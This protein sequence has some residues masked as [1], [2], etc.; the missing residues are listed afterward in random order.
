MVSLPPF[1]VLLAISV[2][3]IIVAW[4]LRSSRRPSGLP[5]GPP[6]LPI[7][8]NALEIS[9]DNT[10]KGLAKWGKLYG[11][12][13]AVKAFSQTCIVINSPDAANEI[14]SKSSATTSHRIVR[15][16]ALLSGWE[17]A[18]PHLQP[19]AEFR[20]HRQYMKIAVG[21]AAMME[22][23]PEHE[24]RAL[25]LVQKL[26]RNPKEI[27]N[28]VAFWIAVSFEH[29]AYGTDEEEDFSG[30][31]EMGRHALKIFQETSSPMILWAVDIL[32]SL[33]Y[34]PSWLPGMGF[35]RQA[36]TWRMYMRELLDKAFE[37]SVRRMEAGG[38]SSCLISRVAE[39]QPLDTL[40]ENSKEI[41]KNAALNIYVGGFDTM[42]SMVLSFF[43][44]MTLYPDVQKGAQLKVDAVTH[45]LRL[46]TFAD[47]DS[48]PCIDRMVKEVLRWAVPTTLVFPHSQ[49]P[50]Q[51]AIV[52]GVFIP[53]GSLLIVN[54]GGIFEDPEIY[55]D[56]RRFWPDRFLDDNVLDP[57]SVAFGY[58]R[59]KCIGM[60][61]V[62]KRLWITIATALATLDVCAPTN[63]GARAP[64]AAWT[65]GAMRLPLSFDAVFNVRHP[66]LIEG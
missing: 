9:A 18:L 58:A 14:L 27:Y 38:S 19:A 37:N 43:L 40:D 16:M 41:L 42:T 13:V 2:L 60:H 20:Q 4:L 6:G 35:K 23:E 1:E 17:R 7:L 34:L 33:R 10:Y 31:V 53:K 22:Y 66:A 36:D 50:S 25:Q 55:A 8:G 39:C 12:V 54:T 47:R 29:V 56:P 61:F 62:E 49:D 28:E 11:P 30:F 46:P 15:P 52:D 51:D 3:I 26:S 48:L 24:R 63:P 32:P 64:R 45:G 65:S 5:P 59:R 21:A 44:A 57:F